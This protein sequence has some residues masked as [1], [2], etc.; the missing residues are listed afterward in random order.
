MDKENI[1][2]GNTEKKEFDIGLIGWWFASNYGSALTYYALGK[3]LEDMNLSCLMIQ[4]PKTNKTPWEPQTQ[5]TMDFIGKYFTISEFRPV[6]KMAEYNQLCDNFMLGS[7]QLWTKL[8]IELTGYTFFLDFAAPEKRK[9]AFATSFGNEKFTGTEEQKCYASSILKTFDYI[10]V[11]EQSGISLCKEHFGVDVNRDLDPVFICDKK[12]YDILSVESNVTEENYLLCYI[13]DPTEEKQEA[14]KYASEKLGLKIIALLDMKTEDKRKAEWHTGELREN[15]S[16]EDFVYYFKHCKFLITDSH[17]GVCFGIIYEKNFISIANYS[18][19]VTRF[20]HLL[21][22]FD[23][24]QKL[25]YEPKKIIE[26]PS[27]FDDIDYVKVKNILENEKA[28]SLERLKKAL[29]AEP[30]RIPIPPAYAT[31]KSA[32]DEKMCMGCSAC[33]NICPSAALKLKPDEHGYYRSSINYGK[34]IGCELCTKICPAIKLPEKNNSPSPELYEFIA[35]DEQTLWNSS[36]GGAFS[37]LAAET[38]KRNGVVVGAAWRDDFAVEHIMIERP[39]DLHKL[40]KSKYLQT[41]MGDIHAK[42]RR[43]L[44]K[45]IFVLFSGCPCQIAGLKAFLRKEYDNLITVDLLCGNSPSA[46]FFKKYIEEDF[47]VG[48]EK[49]EFRHKV[50]GWNADCTT[51]TTDGVTSVRRGQKQDNFQRVYHNHTMCP[52]HCEKCKYQEVPRFGDI[53]IGDFWGVADKDPSV[54]AQKGISAVLCN[55]QKGKDFFMQIPQEAAEVRKQVPLEWLGGNGYAIKGSHNYCSPKRDLFYESI[56][57]MP[58]SEAVNYAL[59][60]NHGIYETSLFNYRSSAV[61]F[62]FDSAVWD[63]SYINGVTVLTTRIEKPKSGCFCTFPINKLLRIGEKYKLKIR[64]KLSTESPIMNFH[65][66][67]SGSQI[68]QVIHS[69]SVTQENISQWITVEKEFTP[70]CDFYDEF[71]MGA[72]QLKG[73]ERY[74][75]IDFISIEKIEQG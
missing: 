42:T 21:G 41:Y 1:L 45:G 23:L 70:D 60:P 25:V 29:A 12:H 52:P 24:S 36:S 2:S 73:K 10:S 62:K 32:L 61:H 34:C 7:D 35:A 19:G 59:K 58:F 75:A 14:I 43:K 15:P 17:H 20:T 6:E 28:I 51:I 22:L 66:K 11:R 33:V 48:L 49:Y 72:A 8:S 31:V 46:M 37:L 68:Y 5:K 63:E 26:D 74:I 40:Q 56:K 54:D 3:I 16:V 65:I 55:N 67:D 69:H 47:P 18:R 13:L 30:V 57:S 39:E 44:E 71:M 38:F 9:I 4:I 50:N 64:F 27:F 53:T